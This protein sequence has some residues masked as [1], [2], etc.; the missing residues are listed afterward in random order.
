MKKLTLAAALIFGNVLSAQEKPT[1]GKARVYVSDSESWQVSGGFAAHGDSNGFNAGGHFSGGA[2]PQTVELIKTFTERCP[3]VIATMDR[4]KADYVVLFDREGGKGYL[5]K[6][7]KIAVFKNNGDLV[8]S[9]S[10]RS[11]GNA[12]QDACESLQKANGGISTN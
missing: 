12:V 6:R 8:Y 3:G 10:T 7:D 1:D 2:R 4:T 9:G 5:R 11:V